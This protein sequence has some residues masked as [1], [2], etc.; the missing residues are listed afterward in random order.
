MHFK[1]WQRILKITLSCPASSNVSRELN[2]ATWG[3]GWSSKGTD[4]PAAS[5]VSLRHEW[6]WQ[7]K[8]HGQNGVN[9]GKWRRGGVCVSW[10]TAAGMIA[11]TPPPPL[12]LSTPNLELLPP[13]LPCEFTSVIFSAASSKHGHRSLPATRRG[14]WSLDHCCNPLREQYQ[15]EP[16]SVWQ[17]RPCCH[18]AKC[19]HL[20][21]TLSR[22]LQK[23]VRWCTWP[24]S[25]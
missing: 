16:P 20:S 4:V 8:P 5:P 23:S 9:P 2:W 17:I 10:W 13:G 18:F 14:D 3:G 22:T 19:Q 15:A 1:N 21:V 24:F 11:W 25:L 12:H 6:P 7:S